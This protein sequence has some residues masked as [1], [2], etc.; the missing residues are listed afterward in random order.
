MRASLHVPCC[1]G[2]G[3]VRIMIDKDHKVV[4]YLPRVQHDP[5]PY[6]SKH[7]GHMTLLP[8]SQTCIDLAS[9][10]VMLLPGH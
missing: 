1:V 4:T 9:Q 5:A 7:S 2:D 6:I 8:F 3:C 10:L